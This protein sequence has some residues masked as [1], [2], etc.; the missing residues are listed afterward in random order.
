MRRAHGDAARRLIAQ[1]YDAPVVFARL[2]S[3]YQQAVDARRQ[4]L[5]T[6]A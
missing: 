2:E 5:R 4:A 3:D 6:T 1:H